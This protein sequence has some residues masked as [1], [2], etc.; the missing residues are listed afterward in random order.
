MV[1]ETRFYTGSG[2]HGGDNTLHPALCFITFGCIQSTKGLLYVSSQKPTGGPRF[3][4][5]R[6]ATSEGRVLHNSD[7][8]RLHAKSSRVSV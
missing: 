8:F 6:S 2:S 1:I 7:I 4:T 3:Y 5:T